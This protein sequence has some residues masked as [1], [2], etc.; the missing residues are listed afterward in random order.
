MFKFNKYANTSNKTPITTVE[1]LVAHI[2]EVI[3]GNAVF[4]LNGND[5]GL[6]IDTLNSAMEG[7]KVTFDSSL[8]ASDQT[9]LYKRDGSDWYTRVD[10]TTWTIKRMIDVTLVGPDGELCGYEHVVES[11]DFIVDPVALN[12]SI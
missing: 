6:V 5:Y 9:S 1:E 7:V 10:G 11:Y 3:G 8:D 12:K 2:K 4:N